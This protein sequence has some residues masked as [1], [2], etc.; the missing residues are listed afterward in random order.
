MLLLQLREGWNLRGAPQCWLD[1]PSIAHL[2]A[3]RGVTPRFF[4]LYNTIL[5]VRYAVKEAKTCGGC[6]VGGEAQGAGAQGEAE[7]L[8]VGPWSWR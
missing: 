2:L 8:T 5:R 4:S 7:E 1:P 6:S 3:G